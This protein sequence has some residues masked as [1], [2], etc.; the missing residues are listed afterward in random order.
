MKPSDI[1]SGYDGLADIWN[2]DDFDRSNGIEQHRRAIAFCSAKGRALDVG[3]GSSGRIIELMLENGFDAEGLDLSDRML[4]LARARHPNTRFHQADICEWV[5]E[6][7]YDFVSAWDSIWHVPLSEQATVLRKLMGCLN[8]NGVLVFTMGGL[9]AES[10]IT[11]SAMGPEMYYST[12]GVSK[13]LALIEETGC[14]CRH[15]EYDQHPEPHVYVIVQKTA[16]K[17]G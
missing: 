6:N 15:L 1:A 10:E 9:D 14:T 4:E 2:G 11:D 12:L 8:T 3:C 5:A 16:Q 17:R 7:S 13:T